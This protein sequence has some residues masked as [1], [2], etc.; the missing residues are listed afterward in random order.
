MKENLNLSAIINWLVGSAL[1]IVILY[2]YWHDLANLIVGILDNEDFSYCILLPLV[3]GYIVYLK[4][5]QIRQQPWRPS[6]WG[7]LLLVLW[8]GLF[9]ISR[10]IV[11]SYTPPLSFFLLITGLMVL[12]G[13]WQIFKLLAFPLMLL[14]IMIPPPNIVT[15]R[16]TLPLQ[17][18][19]S[20]LAAWFLQLVGIPLVLQGN[21]IDLGV[22]QLQVVSACSGLRYILALLALGLIFCYFFQRRYWKGG[23]LIVSVIPAAILANAARVS[24]MAIFPSLQE[25]FW[26]LFSGW[27]IFIFCFGLLMLLNWLLNH[28]W[29]P[30]VEVTG[31]SAATAAVPGE[32]S[33]S[34]IPFSLASRLVVALI[35]VVLAT[36]LAYHLGQPPPLKLVQSFDNFPLQLGPWQG[37]RQFMDQEIFKKTEASD[38]LE[39]EYFSK[40]YGQVSLYI[41]Y[42]ERQQSFG[43]LWHTPQ[44]CMIGG[45]WKTLR[46][47]TMEIFPKSGLKANYLLQEKSGVK[48]L[49]YFWHLQQGYPVV[50]NT[51]RL[52]MLY[53]GILKR[54]TDWA[55]IRLITPVGMDEKAAHERLQAFVRLLVPVLPHFLPE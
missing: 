37:R 7:I 38:Y 11:D 49:V 33:E 6:S 17:L 14:F 48:L 31:E 42:Y 9:I 19:S 23:V 2:M 54:R 34:V 4:W 50:D 13:G 18:L 20:Q 12:L 10:M 8:V 32:A 30:P 55:L 41:A 26:H 22:R 35:L 43:G 21:I 16:I 46:D 1:L 29:P 52:Y 24:A 51:S 5:P 3:S 44:T 47:G 25:G 28:F 40:D 36:P 15:S 39:A 27:L 53:N 45:G